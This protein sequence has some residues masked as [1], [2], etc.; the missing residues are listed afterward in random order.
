M[1]ETQVVVFALNRENCGVE[2][3]Q[4]QKIVK[5]QDIF[6]VA[7]MPKF[8][9]GIFNYRGSVIPAIDLNKR[10]EFGETQITDNTK[11]VVTQIRNNLVGFIVNDVME[12]LTLSEEDIEETPEIISSNG[13]N[14]LKCVGK[15]N[16]KLISILDLS[17]ILNDS[18]IKKIDNKKLAE[19]G[20][21]S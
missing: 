18:E 4:V 9:E 17:L 15:K 21:A 1:A 8:I 16:E 7:K 20:R 12:I 5:Y 14:F 13:N 3:S 2:T 6:K 11:I 19:K 10:F